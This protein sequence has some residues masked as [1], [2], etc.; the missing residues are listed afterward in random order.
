MLQ[1]L[2]YREKHYFFPFAPLTK[3]PR[4][5]LGIFGKRYSKGWGMLEYR[6]G[7]LKHSYARAHLH[8]PMKP[9][10]SR[11]VPSIRTSKCRCGPVQCPVQ[12]T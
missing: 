8:H 7:K 6:P 5:E 1:S 12:P 10:G 3:V 9:I 11:G 2:R 4:K